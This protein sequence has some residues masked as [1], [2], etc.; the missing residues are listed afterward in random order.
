MTSA[1]LRSGAALLGNSGRGMVRRLPPPLRT[2]LRGLVAWV[3]RQRRAP[4]VEDWAS[5][6]VRTLPDSE[7]RYSAPSWATASVPAAVLIDP[8]RSATL[9][10]AGSDGIDRLRCLLVTDALDVGGMDEVVAFLA[11]RLPAERFRTAVLHAPSR[12]AATGRPLGRL[13]R[14]LAAGGIEVHECGADD[15][16]A[17]IGQ[18]RPD[19]ISAHCAPDWVLAAAHRL[20]VPY[21]DTLHGMGHMYGSVPQAEAE[22]G[23]KLAAVAAV[24]EVVRRKYLAGNPGFPPA[25][26]VTIP[27]GV[28]DQRRSGGD[29]AAA[30][31]H[32]G[33]TSEYVFVSLARHHVAKN[34]YGLVTAFADLAR[35]RPEVHLVIAGRADHLRY[36]RQVLRLRDSLPCADRIHLRD[37]V[38]SPADLLVA[39]DGFVM[40]SFYEGGPLASMEALFAGVPV[41]LSDVGDAREQI[42]ADPSRGHLV[43][44]P[45]GC[46]PLY[47]DWE[48]IGAARYRSQA[49]RDELVV[50]MEHLVADRDSYLHDRK[51]LAAESAER[52]SAEVCVS[53]H[54]ALLRAVVASSDLSLV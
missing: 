34:T 18:W 28:D 24:S 46:D 23:T 6:L 17:W 42:G 14:V 32:L 12:P 22:R 43:A 19:V 1:T 38:A 33:L 52:F 49:N 7:A 51:L 13:G 35:R 20:G 29:R 21:V 47:V 15:G 10:G 37:H 45:I 44:N 11:S 39:A 8:A 30:R 41:V 9:E 5:P 31:Y 4:A 26:I 50:A 3:A 36:Y 40:D 25:K 2:R 54:A 48:S 27:N 16:P 53:R